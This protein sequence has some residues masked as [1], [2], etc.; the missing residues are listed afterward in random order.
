MLWHQYLRIYLGDKGHRD[1]ELLLNGWM[2]LREISHTLA[3]D[4]NI[5][6]LIRM[7]QRILCRTRSQRKTADDTSELLDKRGK[8]DHLRFTAV[9]HTFTLCLPGIH[10]REHFSLLSLRI[11]NRTQFKERYPSLGIADISFDSVKQIDQDRASKGVELLC[12]RVGK[13]KCFCKYFKAILLQL[14][15]LG[16]EITHILKKAHTDSALLH[17]SLGFVSCDRVVKAHLLI[18][19]E[20]LGFDIVDPYDTD[21]LFCDILN[22]LDIMPIE[23]YFGFDHMIIH[24]RDTKT[25]LLQNSHNSVDLDLHTDD[26]GDLSGIHYDL[27]LLTLYSYIQ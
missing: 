10:Y 6:R 19:T 15:S 11:K 23:R 25:E 12:D 4:H 8:I 20:R 3:F 1:T 17:G 5:C 26:R 18:K 14:L 9:N 2:K 22:I 7:D 21:N 16:K 13:I 24:H 27:L